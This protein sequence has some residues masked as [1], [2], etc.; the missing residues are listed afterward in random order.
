M[1]SSPPIKLG[2]SIGRLPGMDSQRTALLARLGVQKGLDLL[3]FFPRAYENPA[4]RMTVE[5]FEENM[6]VS[7]TGTVVDFSEKVTQSG[8]HMF[9]LQLVP[10]G[11]G[12]VRL[13][14]FNQMFRRNM[15]RRGDR[16]IATG[17]L[18]STGL[19]WEMVQ[20]QTAPADGE[21][22]AL[23]RPTPVYPLTEGLKQSQLRA[24]MRQYIPLLIDEVEEAIPD[25][26]RAELELPT[27]QLAL[28][29]IH[30]PQTVDQAN[31]ARRRF[32]LQELLVLQLALAMQRHQRQKTTQAP[33]CE[34][35]GKIHSR[36]LNRL[37]FTLTADQ[38]TAINDIRN[39]MSRPVPMNRL[40][41]GDVGS[42]KTLV[43]QYAMLLCVANEHQAALMAPTE[44]LARQHF[45]S[46]Q[47][48]L[49]HSRVRVGLLVGSL[50]KSQRNQ[51]L[52]QINQGEVDL[53]VGTQS[54][55]SDDVEFKRLGLVIVDEQHKFGVMQRARMRRDNF[56][57][58]YLILSA[59]PI[60]RTIAMSAFGDLD[61][62]TIKT[63]PPGRAP[64]H[65]Y[66][67]THDQLDSWWQFVEKQLQQG[68]QAYVI[69]PRV[70][71]AR[72]NEDSE[73]ADNID[74]THQ[75]PRDGSNDSDTSAF[76]AS[77]QAAL[78]NAFDT[79]S[80]TATVSEIADA[81][82]DSPPVASA[83]GTFQMLQAGPFSHRKIGLLHGR[84]DPLTKESVLQ[85]FS[86]GEL[87]I[88]VSTTVVEVGIDVPNATVI[89]ILDANRLG[90]SQLHQL[91]GRIS[92]GS[93]PGYACAVAA[94]GCDGI[95]NQR[96]KAFQESNDG[97]ELAEMDLRI[98]GPGDLLGTSQTGLP[99]MRIANIVEDADLLEL[100]R[101]A[102]SEILQRDPEL[103]NPQLARLVQQT[104]RRYG[105]S[106]QLGDVG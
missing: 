54:L 79:E 75:P 19:N 17:V 74:G 72:L 81:A 40:L 9:G 3:F 56:Q 26:I 59:T 73:I 12:S 62:S 27:I 52:A 23:D 13:M 28:H 84:L 83:E 7:F 87:E 8:K 68:R 41:Q 95:D 20:P 61:V 18:R 70:A 1:A 99:T 2:I 6:R 30:F 15:Y 90:L 45:A 105:K 101:Q 49:G 24:I 31:T 47:N 55:L 46:L 35:S 25:S 22:I 91:R 38:L 89:T 67:A 104:L 34:P 14:W 65:T 33:V 103:S 44:V 66:L 51:V 69:A 86:S 57:P 82:A 85:S 64:V 50:T 43:A 88:L 92:R 63:K 100:A 93:H 96:L 10:E 32:K 42:G 106:L 11:G 102:A 94:P 53:V 58:H 16:L 36:I 78:D 98:R 77:L 71:D 60:P 29:Q 76:D 21:E 37:Q 5:Q 4:P 80:L 39:D 97:F 48:S